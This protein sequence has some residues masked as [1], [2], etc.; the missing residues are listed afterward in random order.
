MLL[1]WLSSRGRF[2]FL[3]CV[4]LNKAEVVVPWHRFAESGNSLFRFRLVLGLAG[5][6]TMLP[7]VVL[8]VLAVLKMALQET[9]NLNGIFGVLG[10]GAAAVLLGV[11]FGIAGK[12][13]TDFVAP[14][15]FL[16]GSRCVAAWKEFLGLLAANPGQ[17]VLYFL[18]QLVLEAAIGVLILAVMILT[19]CCCCLLLVP[20]VRTVLLLPVLVFR[21]SY[22]LYYF[23]QFG[24]EYDVFAPPAT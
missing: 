24:R 2:M 19:L 10:L 15:M 23:A 7:L 22:S 21:R 18:F 8:I 9:W 16:R 11:L 13:T 17:F 4:A 5:M 20:Y 6:I 14:I 12:L 3:H 1:L